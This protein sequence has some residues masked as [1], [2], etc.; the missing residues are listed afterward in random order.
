MPNFTGA[1]E[2][3][4]G[5]SCRVTGHGD[6][7]WSMP[8]EGQRVPVGADLWP[9]WYLSADTI[10]KGARLDMSIRDATAGDALEVELWAQEARVGGGIRAALL[11]VSTLASVA[12][13]SVL[14]DLCVVGVS[15][16]GWGVRARMTSARERL[17]MFTLTLYCEMPASGLLWRGEDVA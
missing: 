16:R 8:A 6:V 7:R 11:T 14:R 9:I 17:V 5:D 1:Y 12:S 4:A 2:G 10:Y 15:S 3:S 13:Q